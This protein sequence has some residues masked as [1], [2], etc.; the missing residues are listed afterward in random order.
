MHWALG[1]EEMARRAS[2]KYENTE[3]STK[4]KPGSTYTTSDTQRLEDSRVHHFNAT[5]LH[6]VQLQLPV[7]YQPVKAAAG[8][9]TNP[10][11]SILNRNRSASSVTGNNG[12]AKVVHEKSRQVSPLVLIEFNFRAVSPYLSL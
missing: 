6:Q 1:R 4:K 11:I 10:R 8:Q 5:R 7:S 2:E 9:A 3:E 12:E